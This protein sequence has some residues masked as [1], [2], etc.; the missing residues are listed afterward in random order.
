MNRVKK[1][2]KEVGPTSQSA[3]KYKRKETKKRRGGQ[4][5]EDGGKKELVDV[6]RLTSQKHKD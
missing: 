4:K 5:R 3:Q 2:W 6:K 1:V